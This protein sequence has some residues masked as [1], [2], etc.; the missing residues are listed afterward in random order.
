MFR[1]LAAA[2]L[3]LAALPAIAAP[4]PFDG[5]WKTQRFSLFSSNDYGFNGTSVSVVSDGSVSLAYRALPE[6]F[7]DASS[8]SWSWSVQEGVPATDLRRKGGDDRNLAL[9]FVFLP[10]G[11]AQALQGASV[12]N[13]LTNDAARVL[14][15]VWGGAHERGAVLDSPY[16]GSRGK[17]I[18]LRGAGTGSASETVNLSRD[19]ADAFGGDAALVGIA[20]SGDSDDTDSRI[21]ASI[22]GL[23]LN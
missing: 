22:S 8:A 6:P 18:V 16:L 15:Y 12:R 23:T 2:V 20:L 21:R 9:Y 17:T 1:V 3:S 13:L 19:F 4:V 5:S 7:W 10:P 14:V 11:Q